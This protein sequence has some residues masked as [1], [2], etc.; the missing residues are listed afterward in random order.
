MGCHT[1]QGYVF[2]EPMFEHEYLA[3]TRD[4]GFVPHRPPDISGQA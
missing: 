1:I 2:A 4:A 3:W